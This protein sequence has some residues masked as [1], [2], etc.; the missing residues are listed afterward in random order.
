LAQEQLHFDARLERRRAPRIITSY[1]ALCFG[2]G[3][4]EG[5]IATVVTLLAALTYHLGFAHVAAERFPLALYVVYSGM[6]GA[7]YGGYSAFSVSRFLDK[8]R[9]QHAVLADSSLGWTAAFAITLLFG[10]LVGFVHDLSR[11]SLISAYLLGL[12]ILLVVRGMAYAAVSTRIS[13]GHLQYQKVGVIGQRADVVRFL[14]HGNL[15]RAGYRLAGALHLEDLRDE[16]GAIRQAELLST[17]QRWVAQ[18]TDHFVIVGQLDDIAQLEQLSGFLKRFSVNIVGAPATDNTTLKFIDVVPI[19]ANNVLRVLRKP[20]GEGAVLLKRAFDLLGATVGL[21]LLSPLFAVVALL[22]SLDSRGPVFYRQERRGF[23]GEIFFIWKFRSMRVTESG[24]QMT[25]VRQGDD[26]ITRVGR[27]IRST[28][29]DELPQLFNVLRGE[30]SLVGP[31]PHALAH[32]DE[33]GE[34]IASY[35]HRQRIKPGITGWAQVNG[36]RGATV[37]HA[38]IEGRT[39]HDLY[40]IDN[41]SIFLDCWIIVLT[42]FSPKARSNAI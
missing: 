16:T 23:N 12:P 41:W 14:F 3:L 4:T 34:Q 29:I 38:Q 7:I 19:G 36:F 10:F 6:V 35:A 11:V 31:R 32:D 22:V 42:V 26:R 33:L 2:F 30:M 40:Y 25:Q 21:I 13:T 17:A 9:H 1:A 28:S 24:R 8:V 37:T 20:M 18:G 39:S 5:A 27:F 15:W